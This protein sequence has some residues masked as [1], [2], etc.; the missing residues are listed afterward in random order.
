MAEKAIKRNP[1]KLNPKTISYLRV[2]TN[3]QDTGKF[4]SDVL[5]FCNEK[6]IGPVEFVEEIVSGRKNWKKR[7]IAEVVNS[8]NKGDCLVVPELT[9]LGRSTLEV[10]EILKTVKEKG[11]VAYSVKERMELN[12]DD[13]Q[14][15]IMTTM[16][17][18]FADV[19]RDFIS[20]RTREALAAR[21]KA[22]VKLGRP[23]GPGKSKLDDHKDDVIEL[24]KLGLAKV[25]VAKRFGVHR[26]T[27]ENWLMK[28][29]IDAKPI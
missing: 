12:G 16:L 6:K 19:E 2:S 8:L 27:L 25:K 21:K 13:I 1:K 15:K 28:N 29:E 24:L 10:L 9:R 7:Q 17:A 23:K 22:G 3:D 14:S 18:L 20:M 5:A 11:A 26:S 4:K